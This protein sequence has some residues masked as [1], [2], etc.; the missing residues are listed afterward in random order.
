MTQSD[1]PAIQESYSLELATRAGNWVRQHWVEPV[2]C[3]VCKETSWQI[4]LPVDHMLRYRNGRAYTMLPIRCTTCSY[5]MLFNMGAMPGIMEEDEDPQLHQ[6][7]APQPVAGIPDVGAS[8]DDTP[9]PK[10]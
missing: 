5:V 7:P 9:G 1:E 4:E 8:I 10:Q 6:D 3:P 2:L